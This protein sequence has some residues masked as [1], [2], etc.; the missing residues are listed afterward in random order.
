VHNLT[1]E[2]YV[3]SAFLNPDPGTG[4][5]PAVFEPGMP[6]SVTVSFSLGRR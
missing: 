2:A 5:Q 6:R 3:G 1:D 4:G